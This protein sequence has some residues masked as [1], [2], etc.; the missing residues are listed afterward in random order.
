MNEPPPLP[1]ALGL[2][3]ANWTR[4]E[5]GSLEVRVTGRWL[6]RR[7]LGGGQPLLVIEREGLRHRFPAMP[8]PPSLT[9]AAPG[10][11]QMTFI[12][13]AALA[14]GEGDRAW[15]QFG[16]MTIPLPVSAPPEHPAPTGAP[17]PTDA[18][19]AP[20]PAPARPAIRPAGPADDE[21]LVERRLRSAELALTS[22][23]EHAEQAE[24]RAEELR[25]QVH[26]LQ[27]ELILARRGVREHD[28]ARRAAEQEAQAE[29]TRR[30]ELQEEL[31]RAAR[32]ED[33]RA[34][35]DRLGAARA[36]LTGYEDELDRLSR[37]LAEAE[38]TVEVAHTDRR[39]AQAA[40]RHAAG[41]SRGA[42]LAREEELA[43]RPRP[44]AHR[45]GESG[46]RQAESRPRAV[47]DVRALA[48][49][50]LVLARRRTAPPGQREIAV[51]ESARLESVLRELRAELELLRSLAERE[52]TARLAAEARAAELERQLRESDARVGGAWR[53]IEELRRALSGA[54]EVAEAGEPAPAPPVASEPAPAP[55]EPS[56]PAPAAPVAGFDPSRLDAAR[57]R[58]RAAETPLPGLPEGATVRPWLR[59]VFTVLAERDPALAGRLAIAL[60]P[61]Q[62]LTGSEPLTYAIQVPGDEPIRVAV[63]GEE[64]PVAVTIATGSEAIEDAA[65][66]VAGDHAAL[67]RRVAAGSVRRRLG[68]GRARI[69]GE[70]TAARVLTGL[71]DA[72]VSLAAVIRAGVVLEPWLAVRLIAAMIEP[73]WTRG[74]RFQLAFADP[75]ARSSGTVLEIRDGG[76]P[77]V[78]EAVEPAEGATLVRCAP[79]AILVV[80]GG[81]WPEGA[82]VRGPVRGLELV[83]QWVLRAQSGESPAEPSR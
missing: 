33:L 59:R 31:A 29:A 18:A 51:E 5:D 14:P 76:I 68:G 67:G 16:T 44:A 77:A 20:E 74:E 32:G 13:S 73:S 83:Q 45:P 55:P 40:A 60:L 48:A 75:S 80:A 12:V 22:S 34:A 54:P 81:G 36:R 42:A 46:G 9:G 57:S 69:R 43:S 27:R 82:E 4:R 1:S 50:Q 35:E 79:G 37:A 25:E 38:R 63:P 8:E 72:E 53:Q 26:G 21:L 56:E 23:R 6:R 64:G 70:R 11:W 78:A 47:S 62:R 17:L 7:P 28:R 49:E 66:T 61:L 19:P 10:T 30:V 2:E 24:R 3:A 52:R 65:F 71:P 15:L 58:L 39:R 41:R